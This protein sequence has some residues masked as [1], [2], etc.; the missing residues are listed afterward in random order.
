MHYI[1]NAC[2][3]LN[4]NSII[5]IY[6]SKCPN[7]VMAYGI[8]Q[9]SSDG[10]KQAFFRLVSSNHAGLQ[11]LIMDWGKFVVKENSETKTPPFFRP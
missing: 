9:M 11:L 6:I 4:K 1:H 8:Y 10:W 7:I 5:F 2:I 3:L